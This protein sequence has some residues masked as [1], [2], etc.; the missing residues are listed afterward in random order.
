MSGAIFEDALFLGVTSH[1]IDEKWVHT[2]ESHTAAHL[3]HAMHKI[4]DASAGE[5]LY[6]SGV[7]V[8]GARAAQNSA[9]LLASKENTLWCV[10]HRINLVVEDALATHGSTLSDL[11]DFVSQI[12][13]SLSLSYA[14]EQ[15]QRV[16]NSRVPLSLFLDYKT[17][18]SSTLAMRERFVQLYDAI[19]GRLQEHGERIQL[20]AR[21]AAFC[22]GDLRRC[23]HILLVPSP[24]ANAVSFEPGFHAFFR[25]FLQRSEVTGKSLAH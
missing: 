9:V 2:T 16:A 12:R 14:L 6:I 18:W 3:A 20:E 25:P 7:V 22:L 8:D 13:S 24:L 17:R 19:E 21:A 1:F 11:R 5:H 4:V 23:R 15:A 10:A